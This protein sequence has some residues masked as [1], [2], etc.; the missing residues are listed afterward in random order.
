[1]NELLGVN[2]LPDKNERCGKPENTA[3]SM[4]SPPFDKQLTSLGRAKVTTRKQQLLVDRGL[5]D[6]KRERNDR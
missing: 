3:H 5:D 1:M 4:V 2:H 6:D